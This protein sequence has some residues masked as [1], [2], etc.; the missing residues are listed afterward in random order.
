MI[1]AIHALTG[2]A[3]G[4]LCRTRVQALAAG[5]ASH[6]VA[7]MLPHRDLTIPQEAALLGGA[8]SIVLAARGAKSN[9]FAGAIGAALPDLENLACRLS[10]S[11]EG[12]SLFPTHGRYHG[13]KTRGFGGQ[14]ALAAVC[15]ASLALPARE[16]QDGPRRGKSA[17]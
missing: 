16:C 7:D 6:M 5:A 4:R 10:A 13:R 14:I 2:A 3:L 8:L 9:E 12:R 1:V 15:L 11:G 17:R